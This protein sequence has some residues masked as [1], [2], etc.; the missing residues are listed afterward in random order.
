MRSLFAKILVWFVFAIVI[1]IAATLVTTMLTYDAGS[2]RQAPFPMMLMLELGEARAAWEHGGPEAL[3]ENLQRF[4]EVTSA[5]RAML[6]DE[7]GKDLLTG[8]S[9]ASLMPYTQGIIHSPFS[10]R[11]HVFA[12]KTSDGRY[13]LF[14]IRDN[15]IYWFL[16]PAHLLVV[17]LIVLMCYAL[18]LYLTKPVR[19]L[20]VAVDR[21][22]HGDLT[23]RAEESRKDELGDLA[24]SFNRMAA[25]IQTLLAA[26][27][28]LLLDISHELRSPLARLSVAV[29]LARTEDASA[30][31]LDRIQ[32]EADRLNALIRELLEVTRTEGD[33]SLRKAENVRLDQLMGEL[34][35]DCSIEAQARGCKL[36]LACESAVTLHGD[37]ELLRR[38]VENIVR[39]AIRYAPPESK[40]EVGLENSGGLAKIRVRDYGPGVPGA[41]LPRLFDAFYRVEQDRDRR[42]GGVGLGL[43]IA[44]RAIEIHKGHVKA[45]N[46]APGLL[47][48][49]ELPVS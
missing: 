22:G 3:R 17:G 5:S 45:S 6:T 47:V 2:S 19:D 36:D 10:I 14:V 37:S 43:S 39:N 38:A 33:P 15:W 49:I 16:Q 25:H 46:A 9:H 12:R 34:V 30:G 40:I 31:F 8:E 44:R 42:S 48:E 18:A 4:K 32:K 13:C 28:R 24:A 41:A 27:R 35:E 29:E 21:L 1:T 26:E 20:R 7:H 23:A 11:A